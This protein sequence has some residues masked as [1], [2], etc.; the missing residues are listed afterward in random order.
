MYLLSF[1]SLKFYILEFDMGI[2]FGLDYVN[3]K[4]TTVLGF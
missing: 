3:C 2:G 4:I 1:L